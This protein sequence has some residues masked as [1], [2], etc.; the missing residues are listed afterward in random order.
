MNHLQ[1]D[2]DIHLYRITN[3]CCSL[4]I[5]DDMAELCTKHDKV[6]I[7]M[8]G[9]TGNVNSI[10]T[11]A[12]LGRTMLKNDN[13]FDAYSVSA[14]RYQTH[15]TIVPTP[16]LLSTEDITETCRT[17]QSE[18]SVSR[19]H[20]AVF[21]NVYQKMTERDSIH[22]ETLIEK[23][24]SATRRKL[25]LVLT[26]CE[27]ITYNLYTK[28]A[29]PVLRINSTLH[30]NQEADYQIKTLIKEIKLKERIFETYPEIVT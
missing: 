18:K 2:L 19:S 8:V 15:I 16:G 13:L 28:S 29:L 11:N 1:I 27:D 5:S 9:K 21:F 24:N 12:I 30:D 14:K 3:C 22:L 4:L 17:I 7:V 25:F 6:R 26:D 23:I 20:F 10:T